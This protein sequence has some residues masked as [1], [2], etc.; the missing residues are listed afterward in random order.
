MSNFNELSPELPPEIW[1]KIFDIL[2]NNKNCNFEYRKDNDFLCLLSV[3]RNLNLIV[4]DYFKSLFK[5]NFN[6][7]EIYFKFIDKIICKI[8]GEIDLE[9]KNY[10]INTYFLDQYEFSI[11]KYRIT[12]SYSIY[13]IFNY[14]FNYIRKKRINNNLF[15]E[16]LQLILSEFPNMDK[17]T[18][19]DLFLV[20]Y[21]YKY[22]IFNQ[23]NFYFN[24][25]DVTEI[26]FR[27]IDK[28]KNKELI[29]NINKLNTGISMIG[30]C[31]HILYLIYEVILEIILEYLS[32][33]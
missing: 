3:N 9:Y 27:E 6:I 31:I 8:F 24:R 28:I 17:D 16:D 13:S 19:N 15:I 1:F 26:C 18:T 29:N 5:N 32:Q 12:F 7:K 2:N 14:I 10:L 22:F 20:F 25:I 11:N 23:I 33:N 4:K 21:K 30:G